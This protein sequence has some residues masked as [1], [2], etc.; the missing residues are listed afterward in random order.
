MSSMPHC[1]ARSRELVLIAISL[2]TVPVFRG[3]AA[4]CTI[5]MRTSSGPLAAGG[6]ITAEHTWICIESYSCVP[7]LNIAI[8]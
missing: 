4:A 8:D 1:A 5:V 3:Q 2:Q 7:E 6:Q